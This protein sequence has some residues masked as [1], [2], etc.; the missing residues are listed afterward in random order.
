MS[1]PRAVIVS[2]L[3]VVWSGPAWAQTNPCTAPLPPLTI[4]TASAQVAAT[5]PQ[6][7]ATFNGVLL[8]TEVDLF[9]FA[10]GASPSAAI[11]VATQTI[12]RAAWTLRPM[13]PDCYSTPAAFLF[14]V[15]ANM[16]L[17]LY[18]RAKGPGGMSPWNLVPVPFG[19]PGEPA[20]LTGVRAIP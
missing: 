7:S 3:L 9:A 5:I 2:V 12:P 13:T 4:V 6:F 1:I 10:K 20:A 16:E 17:D 18:A 11:P 19:R 8:V 15:P 14:G